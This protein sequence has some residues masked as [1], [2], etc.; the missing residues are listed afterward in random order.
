MRDLPSNSNAA[1]TRERRRHQLQSLG[2]TF[3]DESE[4]ASRQNLSSSMQH[5]RR[6]QLR[7][8]GAEF[9]FEKTSAVDKSDQ[10]WQAKFRE[11]EQF[12]R[13]NG[14]VRVPSTYPQNQQLSKWLRNQCN[15][16]LNENS[17]RKL[18]CDAIRERRRQQ[19]RNLG[20]AFP[21]EE[22][23]LER[24]WQEKFRELQ[25]YKED[26]GHVR[27]PL[28][29]P[30]NQELSKWLQH[31]RY[32]SLNEDYFKKLKCAATRERRRQQ[33]Q[34]L[35]VTF[36]YARSEAKGGP[37]ESQKRT[38]RDDDSSSTDS[39]KMRIDVSS[40]GHIDN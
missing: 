17:S 34:S 38:A 6:Q 7:S 32:R 36:P 8:L 21:G 40:P 24:E 35:G 2:V 3:P 37:V 39:K 14:H 16:R 9:P 19:L 12:K 13:D 31:Q 18:K 27:I 10:Q 26:H 30:L 29:Y 1:A 15:D 22:D 4:T 11:L 5:E 28:R 33:L 20:V 23:K 25:Q